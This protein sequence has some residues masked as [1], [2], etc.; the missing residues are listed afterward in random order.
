RNRRDD[1][2][3]RAPRFR[4][5]HQTAHFPFSSI[6]RPNCLADSR[7][8]FNAGSSGF[9]GE[10]EFASSSN[11]IPSFN[12]PS[13]I[14][15]AGLTKHRKMSD[16]LSGGTLPSMTTRRTVGDDSAPDSV[17]WRSDRLSA[18]TTV[19]PPSSFDSV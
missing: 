10:L 9:R 16:Q 13:C 3:F 18:G 6:F 7:I 19:S 17:S 14:R 4:P 8:A 2:Y 1:G 11:W 5:G 12:D 15:T